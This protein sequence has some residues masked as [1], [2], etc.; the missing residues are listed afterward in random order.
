MEFQFFHRWFNTLF[1][2]SA[3]LTVLLFYFQHRQDSEELDLPMYTHQ[4]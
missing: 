3:V 2:V 1:L 4:A